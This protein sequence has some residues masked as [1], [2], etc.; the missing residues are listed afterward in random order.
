[1]P[2]LEIGMMGGHVLYPN[3]PLTGWYAQKASFTAH[4]HSV[5]G[6]GRSAITMV[7]MWT[8]RS[9]T[10]PKPSQTSKTFKF[11]ATLSEIIYQACGLSQTSWNAA[12]TR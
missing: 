4:A 10:A 7:T 2:G 11:Y 3:P 8:Q 12:C 1:M 9:G 6:G 5:G